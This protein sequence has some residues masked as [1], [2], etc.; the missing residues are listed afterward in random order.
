MKIASFT[1]ND[2]SENTYILYDDSL[3]CLIIDPGCNN[4]EERKSLVSYI[5]SN[6]LVPSKLV[7]THCHID[8]V[9][10]NSFVSDKY[11]LPLI[12]HQ[13]EE[14][15]LQ[16]C[17]VVANMYGIPY[18]GSPAISEYL[19]EGD[20]LAFGTTVM[21]VLFTPGHSPASISF[22]NK[23]SGVLIAGDVLFQGSIGRTDLPGG[24]FNTLI[25]SIKQKFFILPEDTTV[26]PGHGPKTTIG[27]EKQFN[28]FLT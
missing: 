7:N 17:D 4:E 24:D 11:N 26:Y 27:Y 19:K 22:Y 25:N 3:E 18:S 13:G 20:Q 15:V 1:F 2:F 12:A 16:S 21:D 23:D 5:D 9:L 14:V 8:H 6:N 28:P 10:G